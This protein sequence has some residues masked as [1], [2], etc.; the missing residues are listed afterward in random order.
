MAE[1]VAVALD[2][3]S[4]REHFTQPRDLVFPDVVGHYLCDKYIRDWFY[5]TLVHAGM[6]HRRE[7]DHPFRFHDLRHTFGTLCA[8]S[9]VPVGDIQ[10]YMGHANLSTTQI[11]MHF[12]PRHNEAQRLTVAFGAS[13]GPELGPELPGTQRPQA[14]LGAA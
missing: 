12:A 14:A 9:G 4:R 3:L 2:G 10:H 13:A 11:Y 5:R 1:Q 8:A 7:G 6:G